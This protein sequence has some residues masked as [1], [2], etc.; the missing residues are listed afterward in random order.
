MAWQI[1]SKRQRISNVDMKASK[2][3]LCSHQCEF[4]LDFAQ[5]P[6]VCSEQ[7]N[8]DVILLLP[9]L[10]CTNFSKMRS[11]FHSCSYNC[12]EVGKDSQGS[13]QVR[14]RFCNCSICYGWITW[15]QQIS[16]ITPSC[17]LRF[18]RVVNSASLHN[19]QLKRLQIVRENRSR[20]NTMVVCNCKMWSHV[21]VFAAA[22]N[23]G[24]WLMRWQT[25][26]YLAGI[27]QT[28]KKSMKFKRSRG[29][30]VWNAD[31]FP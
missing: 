10:G 16:K 4:K 7:H 14:H 22:W 27:G 29:C 13:S 11:D 19:A 24:R 5:L 8:W 15:Q 17:L 26:P 21:G 2:F 12:D 28:H 23:T 30:K 25:A 9:L 18:E 20:K 31:L 3:S 1:I 6:V